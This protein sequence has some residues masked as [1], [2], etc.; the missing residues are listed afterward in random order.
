MFCKK[1][2]NQLNDNARFCPKCGQKTENQVQG[3]GAAVQPNTD[4][5]NTAKNIKS[6]GKHK[7]KHKVPIIIAIVVVAMIA[8]L[9][10]GGSRDSVPADSIEVNSSE[11]SPVQNG[12]SASVQNNESSS[13]QNETVQNSGQRG[14]KLSI[15]SDGELSIIRISD[16]T[17]PLETP[18]DGIW[19]VFV[20][21][22]GANLESKGW[23]ATNDLQEMLDATSGNS[24]LR[25]VVEAGGSY[26]WHNDYCADGQNTRLVISEG[27]V[28][29]IENETA[30]MG[31]P[32]ILFN[33]LDWGLKNYC[34]Q[35]M[36]LDFWDHGGASITGVCFDERYDPDG[37][38]LPEPDEE[39]KQQRAHDGL[40]LTEIDETLAAL[41]NKYAFRYEVIGCDACLM[42]TIETANILAPYANYMIASE[43]LEPGTGWDYA[44]FGNGV[45]AEVK[46]GA[47]LGKYLC[48]AYISSCKGYDIAT[49]S[50]I[51]LSKIDHFL[52]GFNSYCI[53]IYDYICNKNGIVD[54][55]LSAGNLPSFG[56]GDYNST[57]L[58]LFLKSM[59]AYSAKAENALALMNECIVYMKNG[60]AYNDVGG[61][62]VYFPL[63]YTPGSK[64]IDILKNI[65]VTPYYMGIVDVCVYGKH[66]AGDISGYDSGQW[67]DEGSEYWSDD[68][69]E[70]S[71]NDDSTDDS[72]EAENADT[73]QSSISFSV[74]P[75]CEKGNFNV[76]GAAVDMLNSLMFDEDFVTEH[77][78]DLDKYTFTFSDEGL[79]N[80][81]TIYTNLFAEIDI[82]GRALLTDMGFSFVG[83]GGYYR[84]N[85]QKIVEQPF[86]G[87]TM[88]L[89]NGN[90]LA[91]YPLDRRY[92]EG[93]GYTNFYYAPVDHNNQK[94]YLIF[95]EYYIEQDPNTWIPTARTEY[96]A[97]GT[98]DIVKADYASRL[99]PLKK[100][101][102]I[103]ALYAM[104]DR[105]TF[106]FVDYM[107]FS[108]HDPYICQEDGDL[109]LRAN[110]QYPNG[111]YR[112]RYCINDIYGNSLYT[113]AVTCTVDHNEIWPYSIDD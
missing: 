92:V 91:C 85:N 16:I 37:L 51:D 23:N 45:K 100:D 31:D 5:V 32:N 82:D 102:S 105:D 46:N 71:E 40:T 22:C 109:R 108:G 96:I 59:S 73:N 83:D 65:C 98:V 36:V 29:V 12:E 47:E 2:G 87:V 28:Q 42:A 72:Q 43:E 81:D 24:N 90:I 64:T 6:E 17:E 107:G 10:R 76:M 101:D 57:D 52:L 61:V 113:S 19:T 66:N 80:M 70:S 84:Q 26:H 4:N 75:H 41:Y 15:S 106:E 110:V 63:N 38:T 97:V 49:L 27:T 95:Y 7:K 35:Y 58:G 111:T 103:V 67:V 13:M 94:K 30:N 56:R 48:D 99:E 20:Y 77:I 14:T 25:F 74:E 3:T 33:F 112:W 86:L 54:I 8:F 93:Y 21:M 78:D 88:G 68:A 53:E 44:G 1:C 104:H 55:M 50:V 62:A 69:A 89:D 34:S 39:D 11:F 79:K 60:Y 18:N 9:G